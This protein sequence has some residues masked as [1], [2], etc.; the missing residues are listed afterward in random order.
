MTT[1][2]AGLI[3]FISFRVS[4]PDIPGILWSRSARST[5]S[6]LHTETA[7]YPFLAI[8]TS[9][10]FLLR[11]LFITVQVYSS[12]STTNILGL[13]ISARLSAEREPY[14]DGGPFPDLAFR[15]YP[16]AMAPY[17]VCCHAQSKAGPG[18]LPLGRKEG[19]KYLCHIL[20]LY[21]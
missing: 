1:D 11:S 12:S 5:S 4:I 7:S 6:L 3:L 16:S 8:R 9:Y 14:V 20:S 15:V 2:I 21:P 10:P 19:R 17:Y 13:S 18:P